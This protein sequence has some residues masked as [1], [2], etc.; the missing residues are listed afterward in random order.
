MKI[1]IG[2]L[3]LPVSHDPKDVVGDIRL[4]Q[5][6][7]QLRYCE[8]PRVVLDA[9]TSSGKTLAY[10]IRAIEARGEIPRF[11]T[12]II[13]YPINSLMWDQAFSLHQL[14]TQ[15]IGKKANLM[16]ES[17]EYVEWRTEQSNADVDIYVLNGETLAALAQESRS[18]EGRAIIEL[19]RRNQAES[20]IILTNPEILYYI[21]LY[22]FA[23]TEDLLHILFQTE[24]KKNLLVFD[25]FHLYHGYSLATITY[26][27]AYIQK[28]FDQI[29]FSS[30]TPIDLGPLIGQEYQLISAVPSLDGDIV[31]HPID[32]VVN[33]ARGILQPDDVPNI[34]AWVDEYYESSSDRTQAVKVL[35][36]VSSIMTCLELQKLL[37][38]D[39]PNEVTAIHGLVPP[40]A[41]PH[42]K[43]K[44][45]PIVIGTSAIE[46]GIDFDASSL[47][48]E[49]HDS[50]TFIQRLGRGGRHSSCQIS[51]FLPEL[52]LPS[53]KE[54]IGDGAR[55]APSELNTYIRKSL[56][57]LPSYTSFAT[58][59]CAAPILLAVLMNWVMERPAGGS[60][61]NDG[62]IIRQTTKQL[63]EGSFDIPPPLNRLETQ[64]LRISRESP[65]G[66]ILMMA[67]K[68]SCRSSLDSI[69]AV[70]T[71]NGTAQFDQLSLH[72]LTK[73]HFRRTTRQSLEERKIRIPW[74][75]RHHQ[76]FLEVFGIRE[77]EARVKIDVQ[78]SDF[79]IMP[80]PLTK[81][82]IISDNNDTGEQLALILR[83]QPAYLL[84]DKQDWRLPGLFVTGG[85]YLVVGGDAYL[86]WFIRSG[87]ACDKN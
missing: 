58:S 60:K 74:R 2:P 37:E 63:E 18:S 76:E 12:A 30:A 52:Y 69:P 77:K 57:D 48:M 38:K 28:L 43:S 17:E 22:R 72:E 24:A 64:V 45:K 49:A 8:Y 83:R 70:F 44:F 26:M 33:G 7:S 35:V 56:P 46:V 80:A 50:S 32:L 21:F 75:M 78:T 29:I 19:L 25:E 53:L 73:L 4:R 61:L 31:R 81:F 55:V 3:R 23:K 82:Q 27:L 42:D 10:L 84:L 87:G 40:S 85:G 16:V 9:P 34:K 86:A 15:K 13:V 11:Q 39:Y 79:D 14:I 5:Y 71:L 68:M 66:D 62:E 6:Q 1:Y 47:I 65:S 36:I 54:S 51:A 20:R 41:R 59:N 67:R